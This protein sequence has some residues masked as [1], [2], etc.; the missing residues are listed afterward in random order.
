MTTYTR[1]TLA[2][3]EFLMNNIDGLTKSQVFRMADDIADEFEASQDGG[4]P[5]EA[6]EAIRQIANGICLLKIAH[7]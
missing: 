1:C 6:N 2:R 5:I 7:C 4:R 3:L